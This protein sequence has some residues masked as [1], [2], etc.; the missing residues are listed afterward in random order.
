MKKIYILIIT[1]II[2]NISSLYSQREAYN[3]H[4]GYGC[5]I[6]FNTPDREP[7]SLP[8]SAIWQLEG[9]SVMSNGLGE[10]L[11]YSD[12][13]EVYNR[14]NSWMNYQ[15]I[16]K[17]QY[18]ATM[19]SV[20]F[21]KPGSKN[22]Y[23][24]V[25]CDVAQY[26][27]PPNDG[28][29]YTL[30]DMNLKNGMGDFVEVNKPLW[31]PTAE[32]IIALRHTNG[33]DIWVVGHEWMSK[34]FLSFKF[35][36]DGVSDTVYSEVGS[37]H[38][39][40]NDIYDSTAIGYMKASPRGDRIAVIKYGVPAIEIFRFNRT[41]GEVSGG[42]TFYLPE[43]YYLYGVEFSPDGNL[44]YVSD[45]STTEIFRYDLSAPK[46]ETTLLTYPTGIK[47]L[48]AMQIAPNGKIYV[49]SYG[50]T[51]LH[52]INNPNSKGV[53]EFVQNSVKVSEDLKEKM[54]TYGLPNFLSDF[55]Y[56]KLT[57]NVQ[58]ACPDEMAMLT[59]DMHI[60]SSS[61]YFEWTG[62]A[63][64]QPVFGDTIKFLLND[65][66]I[67]IYYV[68]T[69]IG[70]ET[71]YD[72]VYVD[73]KD[74][75]TAEIEGALVIC[76]SGFTILRSK[77]QK[78]G[79]R[80]FW[81]NGRTDSEIKVTKAGNYTLK[82]ISEFGC[83]DSALVNVELKDK[84]DVEILGQN[85]FCFGDTIQLKCS[86]EHQKYY[87]QWSNGAFTSS[88]NV[89]E[90]G[91]YWV[92]VQ[93]IDG[94]VGTDTIEVTVKD[95]PYIYLNDFKKVFCEGDS[96]YI[97][98]FNPNS[99]YVYWW[100]DDYNN[101]NRTIKNSGKYTIFAANGA[102]CLDSVSINIEVI[103]IP[104]SKIKIVGNNV[105]CS[106][107]KVILRAE[108]YN[109]EYDYLWSN[110]STSSEIEVTQEGM[111]YLTVKNLLG[112]GTIDSIK[113]DKSTPFTT[114]IEKS[115]DY[116]CENSTLI[117]SLDNEFSKYL[118]SNGEETATI[119]ITQAGIYTVTV[120]DSIGC[121]G[122]GSISIE[123]YNI[124]VKFLEQY[125]FKSVCLGEISLL[126]V[127]LKNVSN[128]DIEITETDI[129]SENNFLSFNQNDFKGKFGINQTK[130]INFAFKPDTL[131]DGAYIVKFKISDPCEKWYEFKLNVSSFIN[132]EVTLPN[133][134]MLVGADTCLPIYAK[135]LCSNAN[136]VKMKLT[137]KIYYDAD[138][139][140]VN[141][142]KNLIYENEN[143]LDNLRYVYF[144]TDSVIICQNQSI[145]GELCGISL[146][147]DTET[148][149]L[150]F[151]EI[152]SL[153]KN[154]NFDTIQGSI[155]L[156]NCMLPIRQLKSY[157]PTSI[158]V[159]PHPA[160][161]TSAI[162]IITE[163]KGI[164]ELSIYNQLAEQIFYK[165]LLKNDKVA[166]PIIIPLNISHKG[167]YL[168]QLRTE[169]HI[170]REKFI[171]LEK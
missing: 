88:I 153:T 89:T 143:V 90:S 141:S 84:L 123:E 160:D 5:G 25:T 2:I 46:P 4:F 108:N 36:K 156:E 43:K 7:I 69:K 48:G 126:T 64:S 99:N 170:Y 168:I 105:L 14:R 117:L 51:Y 145:V 166:N 146:V 128:T 154:V 66:T 100:N 150:M 129:I 152:N 74:K 29:H 21:P 9:V 159:N 33:E 136:P 125:T 39:D 79:Y 151:S 1:L 132:V 8:E 119:S 59:A 138:Y 41:T 80:Y 58:G 31:K 91:K 60:Y 20:A 16:L 38:G 63:F 86:I 112:C 104:K 72:S 139:F 157:T 171:I 149:P 116:I 15:I 142:S 87:Y 95:K 83:V 113:I 130:I 85:E 147:G 57:A 12:G 71:Y 158:N 70:N 47:G 32:K 82:I 120:W 96:T 133:I 11:F 37:F 62:P 115:A 98:V 61:T 56:Q 110:G 124:D 162:S 78:F 101:S 23:Y 17:S 106:G 134:S 35:S 67:G 140:L 131:F 49:T 28:I 148:T 135:L 127:E 65:N 3:W 107:E 144:E 76:D 77:Y 163:E 40:I 165:Q 6:T 137:G 167:L 24:I 114:T 118:W 22:L 26:F 27:D 161:E 169:N 92:T 122:V 30:I 55:Y 19:S 50:K 68:K 81:S 93:D 45:Q 103:P 44:L 121:T 164:L 97:E 109:I 34:S 73:Y 53:L 75:P 52:A 10:L 155:K 13:M 54:T 18:S 102:G 111:Y 42:Q 94:C